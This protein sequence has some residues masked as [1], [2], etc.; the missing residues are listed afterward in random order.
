MRDADVVPDRFQ[1]HSQDIC[2]VAVIVD[3]ENVCHF[4]D[5][6]A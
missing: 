2:N 3:D 1:E 6:P 5:L 4:T